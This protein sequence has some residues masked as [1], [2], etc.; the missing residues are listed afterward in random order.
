MTAGFA[1]ARLLVPKEHRKVQSSQ[2]TWVF[3]GLS[4]RSSWGNGHATTYR[5]LLQAL[6]RRGH[7]IVFLE[8]DVPWYRDNADMPHPPFCETILYESLDEL[9]AQYAELIE[10]ADACIVGSYVPEGANVSDFVT[11]TCRGVTGFYD[12]D[13]PITLK[14]LEEQA[15]SYLRR[16]NVPEFDVYFSFTGGPTLRKLC[17]EFGA[18]RAEPLYCAVDPDLYFPSLAE[19]RWSMGYLG[20]FSDD[21]QPTLERLLCT[22][23]GLLPEENFIVAGAQYPEELGWPANVEYRAHIPPQ[24]HREF[25]CAQRATLNVTRRDMV[26]AGYSPSVRLFEAAACGVPIISDEWRGIETFFVP[27]EEILVAESTADVIRHLGGMS[28]ERR[29]QIG[30]RARQRVLREHTAFHRA[31]ALES[32]IRSIR[33]SKNAAPVRVRGASSRA[34]VHEVGE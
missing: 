9:H 21:R 4:I 11:R 6:R 28:D 16:D 30:G 15:C 2:S 12:I 24:L 26:L 19:I 27:D 31:L 22:T 33:S 10:H 23:A 1:R 20:T 7:R 14:G 8:R 5:A 34:Y 13:T 18:R 25:Y 32:T 17:K 3:I 29:S